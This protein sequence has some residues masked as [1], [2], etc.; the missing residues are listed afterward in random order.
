MEFAEGMLKLKPDFEPGTKYDIPVIRPD[1]SIIKGNRASRPSYP[2]AGP[3]K[4][5]W[6]SIRADNSRS[7]A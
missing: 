6:D 2:N 4:P 7:S 5:E 3:D 1:G